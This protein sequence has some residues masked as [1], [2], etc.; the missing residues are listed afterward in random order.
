[1]TDLIE[2]GV[3]ALAVLGIICLAWW[4]SGKP[5]DTKKDEHRGGFV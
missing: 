4:L 5:I 2:F 3:F 1:M